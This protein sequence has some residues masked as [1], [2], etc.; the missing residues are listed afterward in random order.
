M[1][2]IEIIKDKVCFDELLKMI[3]ETERDVY[4]TGESTNVLSDFYKKKCY[5]NIVKILKD[6]GYLW[7]ENNSQH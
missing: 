7:T 6:R 4:L 3:E 1:S 2:E 5:D